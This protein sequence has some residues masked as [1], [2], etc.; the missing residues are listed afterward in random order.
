MKSLKSC[1][2]FCNKCIVRLWVQNLPENATPHPWF[3]AWCKILTWWDHHL[4]QLNF[5]LYSFHFD[6]SDLFCL[7]KPVVSFEHSV[8]NY[9]SCS[10][11]LKANTVNHTNLFFYSPFKFYLFGDMQSNTLLH[12]RPGYLVL[13]SRRKGMFPSGSHMSVNFISSVLTLCYPKFTLQACLL[14]L[15]KD[16]KGNLRNFTRFCDN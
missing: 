13:G 6:C 12:L 4:G 14:N 8:S 7:G 1:N 2:N 10:Y 3:T 9:L 15:S 16:G 11:K 5:S